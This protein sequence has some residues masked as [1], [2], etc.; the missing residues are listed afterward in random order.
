[1]IQFKIVAAL[2]PVT[3]EIIDT[4]NPA[5]KAAFEGQVG[6]L[7]THPLL[8]DAL[9]GN[10]DT[11]LDK[12]NSLPQSNYSKE[13]DQR[14]FKNESVL[15]VSASKGASP[16]IISTLLNRGVNPLLKDNR[17]RLPFQ[18]ATQPESKQTLINATLKEIQKEFQNIES[19]EIDKSEKDSM[20][21]NLWGMGFHNL[22]E[23]ADS[24]NVIKALGMGLN[25]AFG[26]LAVTPFHKAVQG[27]TG[28]RLLKRAPRP[29]EAILIMTK[30]LEAAK[31][32][33]VRFSIDTLNYNV[34]LSET[35]RS[36]VTTLRSYAET[37]IATI[38]RGVSEE[39]KQRFMKLLT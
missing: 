9:A 26:N 34:A 29:T 8:A 6:T 18:F 1:M 15:V 36:A 37:Q 23:T 3:N 11:L 14:N 5:Y 33:D 10:M 4:Q 32:H 12:L 17:D 2:K 35:E 27:F 19:L 20:K 13:L 39:L 25:P 22:C 16:E 21:A 28:S 7:G 30:L 38:K 31:T 24:E